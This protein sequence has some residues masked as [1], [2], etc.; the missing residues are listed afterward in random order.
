VPAAWKVELASLAEEQGL[1][2]VTSDEI[3]TAFTRV[4][5]KI[6]EA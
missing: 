5:E 3:V 2:F 1:P 4:Y 6:L